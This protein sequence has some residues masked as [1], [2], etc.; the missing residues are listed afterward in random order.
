MDLA[1]L[2]AFIR[3]AQLGSVTRAAETLGTGKAHLSRRLARLERMLEVQLVQRSTRS[4]HLTEVGREFF[5]RAVAIIDSIEATREAV[6]RTRSAPSGRLRLTCGTEFGMLRVNGWVN[7]F[8]RQHPD[9]QVEVEYASR[10]IDLIHEGFDLA[11]RL[12]RLADSNLIARKLGTIG[13]GLFASAAYLRRFGTPSVP[14]ALVES[15]TLLVFNRGSAR[16]TWR[17]VRDGAEVEI[18]V[19]GRLAS[20]NAFGL[21][22]AACDGLGIARLPRMLAEAEIAAGTLLP[23][24][25]D[26]RMPGV[27]V[28]AIYPSARYLSPNVRMFIDH[29]REHF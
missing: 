29:A 4:L 12:G 24:L 27:E 6:R 14:Q 13:Y 25:A 20:N 11:I 9:V 5:E 22:D 26:W 19:A 7:G 15:H 18:P 10:L 28:H 16:R 17:F 3:I 2:R 21:R 23:V 8:L 1:D